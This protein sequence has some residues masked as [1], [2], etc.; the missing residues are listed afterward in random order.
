M[1]SRAAQMDLVGRVFETP[2]LKPPLTPKK[3]LLTSKV[4]KM[5]QQGAFAKVESVPVV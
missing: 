3:C 1:M 4:V 5:T 2:D